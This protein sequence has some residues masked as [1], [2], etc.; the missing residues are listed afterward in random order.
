MP[1]VINTPERVSK[2]S[3]QGKEK[4]PPRRALDDPDDPGGETVAPGD[5]QSVRE[6]P[7]AQTNNDGGSM[8]VSHRG[9]DPE[10]HLD[11]PDSSRVVEGDSDHRKME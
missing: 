2:R 9:T 5:E 3:E 8:N 7:R 1:K 6:C 4:D 11:L 10:G